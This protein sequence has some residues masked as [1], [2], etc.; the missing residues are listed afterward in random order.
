ML[1]SFV[2]EAAQHGRSPLWIGFVGNTDVIMV[3]GLDVLNSELMAS[4]FADATEG[5]AFAKGESGNFRTSAQ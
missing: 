5:Q 2:D 3:S 4:S 1:Q